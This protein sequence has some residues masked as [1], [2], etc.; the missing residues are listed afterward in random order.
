M[1][2]RHCRLKHNGD[3]KVVVGYKSEKFEIDDQSSE[4]S[5]IDSS[6]TGTFDYQKSQFLQ[7]GSFENHLKDLCAEKEKFKCSICDFIGNQR[8]ELLEHFKFHVKNELE[9]NATISTAK[10]ADSFKKFKC[11]ACP[12]VTNTKTQYLHH[13][14]FHKSNDGQYSC[15]YCGY[16][17]SKRHLLNQHLKLHRENFTYKQ[18]ELNDM[19]EDIEELTSTNDS[20]NFSDIP[21]VWV[22][23]NEKFSKMFKCRF[24]PHVNL[25][26]VNIQEHEKMHGVREKNLNSSR[27]NDVNHHCTECNYVCNNAGVLSSHSKVHQ[28]LY[29]T[30]HCL[31]DNSK[32]DEEQLQNLMK[33]TN[34]DT[35][36]DTN[37]QKENSD[38]EIIEK[39]TKS[40]NLLYFCQNCP[41]RFL[42]ENEYVIHT[43]F[44]GIRL[45]YK[46][47]YCTYTARQKPHILAHNK[48]H[49][50]EYQERTKFLQTLYDVSPQHLPPQVV[51]QSGNKVWVI[52]NIKD[53]PDEI[54]LT[55]NVNKPSKLLIPLSGTELYQQ[56]SEAEQKH[57]S[58]NLFAE[59]SNTCKLPTE[60]EIKSSMQGNPKFTYP[61]YLKNGVL[62]EKRYKC[63]KCPSAFEKREQYR[64][65]LSLHGS[66]QRYECSHCDYSVKYYANY[67]QH[68]K[69]H[70]STS[71]ENVEEIN[72]D[73]H[74][75]LVSTAIQDSDTSVDIET[76]SNISDVEQINEILDESNETVDNLKIT[77]KGIKRKCNEIEENDSDDDGN[78]YENIFPVS[79]YL[80]CSNNNNNEDENLN[81]NSNLD[82]MME[83]KNLDTSLT[84]NENYETKGTES[85]SQSQIDSDN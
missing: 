50:D 51:E 47:D 20:N 19:A 15:K 6:E 31:V 38:V 16:N 60:S 18:N 73:K 81:N 26:K 71:D 2:Q 39:E 30:I 13:K 33:S 46:C 64:V 23:K 11:V 67:V 10:E 59:D 3:I 36:T 44:H 34:T 68:I 83:T 76:E 22:S 78:N 40:E 69:K 9:E 24:C 79:K 82:A 41:A 57:A 55:L 42:K 12:Y 63:N 52:E 37:I 61:T 75:E 35:S 58:E 21:L 74:E 80:Q 7:D 29:G 65:H 27:V 1:F 25:R 14:K 62:K 28:G 56:K 43:K 49:C 85:T 4:L 17:V 5:Q 54:E 72:F 66:K 77:S 70:K 53:I 84:S 8:E 45:Y 48:V 32:S